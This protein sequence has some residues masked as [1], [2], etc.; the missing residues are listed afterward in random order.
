M[1]YWDNLP[2]ESGLAAPLKAGN[3]VNCHA[4]SKAG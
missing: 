3:F 1:E 2:K 4:T